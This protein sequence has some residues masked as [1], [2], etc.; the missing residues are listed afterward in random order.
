MAFRRQFRSFRRGFSGGRSRKQ[1]PRWTAQAT[2]LTLTA[3]APLQVVSLYNPG[4]TIGAA[5]YEEES[6]FV[7]GVGRLTASLT[8]ANNG[9]GFAALGIL[10]KSAA[11][12][13]VSGGFADPSVAAQLA[14]RDW[15]GVYNTQLPINGG[16]NGYMYTQELDIRVKRR[17]KGDEEIALVA[18]NGTGADSVIVTIDIRILI[19]IRM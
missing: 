14:A 3:A 17:L 6:L 15:L 13:P 12:A 5:V 18:V 8:A 10:K 9:G 7:R 16:T 1:V 2:D 19:V 11:V 4:T